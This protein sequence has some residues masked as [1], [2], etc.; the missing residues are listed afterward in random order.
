[1]QKMIEKFV[2]TGITNFWLIAARGETF[3]M[4]ISGQ[5]R[6]LSNN[7]NSDKLSKAVETV[8]GD[9]RNEI[10]KDYLQEFGKGWK[11]IRVQENKKTRDLDEGEIRDYLVEG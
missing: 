10:A 3:I 11:G 1:M 5:V 6:V 7:D 9:K 2:G 8:R 4:S